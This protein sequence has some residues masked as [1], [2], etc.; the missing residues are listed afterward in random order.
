P[1]DVTLWAGRLRAWPTPPAAAPGTGEEEVDEDTAI[2]A[3]PVA[4]DTVR[5]RRPAP[6]DDTV[7]VPRRASVP[8]PADDTVRVD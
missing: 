3:R 6:A 1:D 5:V 7:H 8:A 2:S 4:D